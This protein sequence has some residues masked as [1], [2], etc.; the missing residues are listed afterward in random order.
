MANATYTHYFNFSILVGRKTLRCEFRESQA[1]QC[2]D[3]SEKRRK[4]N[5]FS[6][7]CLLL[8]SPFFQEMINLIYT[9]RRRRQQSD[10]YFILFLDMTRTYRDYNLRARADDSERSLGY[11]Y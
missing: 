8:R 1:L 9:S 10:S 4:I 5:E 11:K 2:C 6:T 7:E 3:V